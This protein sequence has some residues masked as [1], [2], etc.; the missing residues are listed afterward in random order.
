MINLNL[1]FVKNHFKIKFIIASVLFAILILSFF[2]ADNIERILRLK[3]NYLDSQVSNNEITSSEFRVNYID[4]GQGNSIYIRFPD[5]KTMLIDG[6]NIEYGEKVAKFLRDDGV[7]KID[8]LV[9]SHADADHIAGLNYIL[10]EFEVKN[11][12]RP[13]QIAGT[14][15]T[16][17]NFIVY[18][19]EDL[20][21]FYNYILNK[22]DGNTKISRVTTETYKNFISN[23]YSE[24]YIEDD[25]IY[26]SNVVVFYDG[27]KI[28][29]ENYSIEFFAPLVRD[30]SYNLLDYSNTGGFAT[31]GYGTNNS[32]DNSAII[33]VTFEDNTF[34][35]T[36]DASWTSNLDN[37]ETDGHEEI[38]FINSLSDDELKLIENVSVYLLGHHGSSF[39]SG[40]RL[41]SLVKTRFFI[42]SCSE[43]NSYGHP[44]SDALARIATY[45]KSSD[46]LLMTKD[47]GSIT[48]GVAHG[49]L[50]YSLETYEKN[51]ELTISWELLGTIIYVFA[52]IVIFSVKTKP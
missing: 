46:Y 1:Y 26:S 37:G 32:N 27:L 19:D 5:N 23:I 2:F 49:K 8:Y 14:G 48:F 51:E 35:F 20:A 17:D 29:G 12:F 50:C 43:D 36:G 28:T 34:L 6:G 33:L 18:E 7:D 24:Y 47:Y 42:V 15:T 38:D 45:K 52:V 9:A 16:L 22:N 25:V 39:S 30:E 31:I 10:A 4:V 13:F 44:A 11:I 3:E 41:L 21:S 40:D